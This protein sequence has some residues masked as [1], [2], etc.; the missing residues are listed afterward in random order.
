[1][2]YSPI[3]TDIVLKSAIL[4]AAIEWIYSGASWIGLAVWLLPCILLVDSALHNWPGRF[5]C[6]ETLWIVLI[7]SDS[8]QLVVGRRF[9]RTPAIPSISPNKS[10]EGYIGGIFLAFLLATLGH[11]WQTIPTLITLIAGVIGDLYFSW[12]K[13]RAGVKDFSNLL[14][15]HGG[16]CDRIDS[17]VFA[18]LSLY[19]WGMASGSENQRAFLESRRFG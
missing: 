10:L 4:I 14:G 12:F 3:I 7:Y 17:F 18:I 15:P 9:G 6:L 2:L 19:C 13:R 16:L 11:G 1:M 5:I 8:A